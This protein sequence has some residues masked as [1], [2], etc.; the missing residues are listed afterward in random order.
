MRTWQSLCSSIWREMRTQGDHH[1]SQQDWS[2]D[3]LYEGT[4]PMAFEF[5]G[6]GREERQE[7]R[8]KLVTEQQEH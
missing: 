3:D 2:P 7:R 6:R 8:E 1:A 4:V 5:T